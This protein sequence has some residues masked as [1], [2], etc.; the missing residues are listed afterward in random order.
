MTK[1]L[2]PVRRSMPSWLGALEE[3]MKR[4]L[5]TRQLGAVV[6]GDAPPALVEDRDVFDDDTLAVMEVERGVDDNV[7]TAVLS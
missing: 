1:P 7:R 5:E 4:M 6:E 2:Q 3:P